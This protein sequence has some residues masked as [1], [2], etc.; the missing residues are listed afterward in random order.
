M[1]RGL[2]ATP[3]F[4]R[5]LGLVHAQATSTWLAM[6]SAHVSGVAGTAATWV[7]GW[8]RPGWFKAR[9]FETIEPVDHGVLGVAFRLPEQPGP[10]VAAGLEPLAA[11]PPAGAGALGS[12]G[13]AADSSIASTRTGHGSFSRAWAC[14]MNAAFATGQLILCALSAAATDA[15]PPGPAPAHRRA[16][17]RTAR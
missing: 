15:R 13:A 3:P 8:A 9:L 17:H 11:P 1:S 12:R 16:A 6:V 2:V 4:R 14:A 10:V 7:R 5:D